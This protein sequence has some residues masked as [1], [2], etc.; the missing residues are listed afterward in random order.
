[1]LRAHFPTIVN[2]E[3]N[4]TSQVERFRRDTARALDAS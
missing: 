4:T 1:M 2:G 3:N